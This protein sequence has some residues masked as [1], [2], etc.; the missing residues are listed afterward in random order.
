MRSLLRIKELHDT[1]RTQA[2]QLAD[3]SRTLERRVDEQLAQL[4]RL[5]RLKRFFSP[6]LAELIVS[7]TADDPLR[8][9][10]REITVVF[11]DLRGFTAF[12]ETAEPEELMSVLREYHAEAEV[13]ELVDAEKVGELSLKGCLRPVPAFSLLRL[14]P[15]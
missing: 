11:L 3:W 7:G 14:R 13:E 15:A 2:A 6:Q 5:G 1:V 9:H 12:A 8:S 4:D 10:R